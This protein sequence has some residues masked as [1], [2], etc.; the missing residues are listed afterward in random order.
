MSGPVR[1][2]IVMSHVNARSTTTFLEFENKL[3]CKAG[4]NMVVAN[5]MPDKVRASCI[6]KPG[7]F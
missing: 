2:L 7:G 4:M 6:T 5:G 3:A 1:I